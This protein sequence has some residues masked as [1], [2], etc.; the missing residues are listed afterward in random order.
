E[1]QNLSNWPTTDNPFSSGKTAGITL[2]ASATSK[3]TW[4]E[5]KELL[6]QK[7]IVLVDAR[8]A[9]YYQTEHIPGAIS[10]PDTSTKSE[11]AA[12][13]A[14]YPAKDTTLVVYCASAQCPAASNLARVLRKKW[15]Y[16]NVHVMQGGMAEYRRSEAL[17]NGTKPK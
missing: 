1:I 6:A 10:L 17:G 3:L 11:L 5:T 2:A 7:Q 16:T 4:S 15:G 8:A 12:F 9:E 13:A 14:N